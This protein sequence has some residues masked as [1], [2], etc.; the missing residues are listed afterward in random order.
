MDELTVPGLQN[1]NPKKR[2]S[3]TTIRRPRQEP[4]SPEQSG[5]RKREFFLNA[6]PVST[7][8]VD[9][10]E[11][12]SKRSTGGS[13]LTP[14]RRGY[15]KSKENPSISIRD[16]YSKGESNS[17]MRENKVTKL[18]VKV[19]GVSH[20]IHQQKEENLHIPEPTRKSIRMNKRRIF[21]EEDLTHY[22]KP[23]VDSDNNKAKK[24]RV[25]KNRPSDDSTDYEAGEE[26]EAV[27]SADIGP[28][29]GGE[30]MKNL[31]SRQR[32]MLKGGKD[33][34]RVEFPEGLPPAPSRKSKNKVSE[35]EQQAKKAEAAQR[36]RLQ[37]EKAN[38]ESQDDAIRKIL[39]L[40]S[41]KKKEEKRLKE[42]E[43]KERR[44]ESQ[45]LNESTVKWVMGPTGTVVSFP[46][47]VDLPSIFNSKPCRYPPP[48]EKCAGPA[49][50]NAYRYR[51]SK[52][53]LPL[54]SLECYRA[55]QEIT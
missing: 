37:V 35:E 38:R 42:K 8:T 21:D 46:D 1:P 33:S 55:V 47:D 4:N 29:V 43:Q 22:E 48:R 32:A 10:D 13:Q 14:Y 45:K 41:D 50:N 27:V 52:S 20:T 16:S 53:K 24:K 51:D 40:D 7:H 44:A 6:P 5:F 11:G 23:V 9:T 17:A 12:R 34:A 36:R 54:C 19:R 49:C 2:R 31:T 25:S 30:K 28:H 18:K 39:G 26:E 15:I 3:A